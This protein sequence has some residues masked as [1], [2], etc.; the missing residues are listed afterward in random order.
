MGDPAGGVCEVG[1]CSLP[2]AAMQ[3]PSLSQARPGKGP[4]ATEW[5]WW[6]CVCVY[7]RRERDRGDSESWRSHR[8]TAA[9]LIPGIRHLQDVR[10]GRH[11]PLFPR[12]WPP[13]PLVP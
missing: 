6:E 10:L 1:G 12:P 3:G 5:G 7:M 13:D 2:G 9:K 8:D 4:G 11:L